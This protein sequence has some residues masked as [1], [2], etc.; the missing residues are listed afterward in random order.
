MVQTAFIIPCFDEAQRLEPERFL[1]FAS[2]E[3][4]Q[5]WM[6][7]DGSTDGTGAL[8]DDLARARPG[9]IRVLGLR[10]NAGKAEAVRRG[11]LAAMEDEEIAVVGYAD[12]DLGV[13][14]DELLRLRD[15]L[16][17]SGASIVMGARVALLGHDIKRHVIRHGLSRI[18]ATAASLSLGMMV[19]DTQCGAKLFRV[20]PAVRAALAER[21]I[22]R[23]AFDVELIGRLV[24]G[25]P[26]AP[27]VALEEIIEE[28]LRSF[29]HVSGG[30]LGIT[31]MLEAG[32]DMAYIHADLRRRRRRMR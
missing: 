14:L 24:I 8:L 32:R 30:R 3:Q 15:M 22:S 19:Y 11:L 23:W 10:Q 27:P 25:T 26:E 4:A 13:P 12:A 7:D 20:S 18:F 1:E 2:R 31:G 16:D 28:P 29:R 17:R 21:F 9:W 5:L 6:V